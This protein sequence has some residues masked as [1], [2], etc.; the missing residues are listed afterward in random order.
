MSVGGSSL[1]VTLCLIWFRGGSAGPQRFCVCEGLGLTGCRVKSA[2]SQPHPLGSESI[3]YSRSSAFPS[4]SAAAFLTRPQSPGWSG[5]AVAA[6]S[7]RSLSSSAVLGLFVQLGGGPFV[8]LADFIELPHVLE[9]VGA[10]LE[11]DEEL[12]LLAVS[13]V[14]GGLNCDGLGSDLLESGV[15]VPIS[16]THC[17]K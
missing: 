10:S 2:P 12:R 17:Q 13:S 4:K 9:E 14:V 5:A 11:R 15:V 3:D 1:C 7:S 6:K 8:L 16:T